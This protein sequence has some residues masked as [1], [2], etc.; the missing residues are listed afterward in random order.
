MSAAKPIDPQRLAVALAYDEGKGEAPRVVAKGRGEVAE[1][2]V[3]AAREH[4][5]AIQGSPML[6]AALSRV[7]LD[8]SIPEELFRAVA[9]V[10]AFVLK[11]KRRQPGTRS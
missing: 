1:K 11:A 4:G 7:E 3:A 8:D 2:I 9:E 5:V 6:A 10:I